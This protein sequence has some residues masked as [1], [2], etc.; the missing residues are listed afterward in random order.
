MLPAW[1]RDCCPTSL[2]LPPFAQ[3]QDQDVSKGFCKVKKT[4]PAGP[5]PTA[6][7]WWLTA[8]RWGPS[9]IG[10][11]PT[12][13][14]W[15]PTAVGWSQLPS[16]GGQ[17][18]S[19]GANCHQLLA[20]CRRLEPTA[21]GCWPTAICW[22]P[23]AI[24]WW[25]TAIGWRPTQSGSLGD[26]FGLGVVV[27]GQPQLVFPLPWSTTHA[28]CIP[29]LSHPE[30]S[31]GL[32]FRPPKRSAPS[33]THTRA[34]ARTHTRA[35]L[36]IVGTSGPAGPVNALSL[37]LS[38]PPVRCPLFPPR[39]L[40]PEPFPVP[41]LGPPPTL[42]PLAGPRPQELRSK[43]SVAQVQTKA[44]EDTHG[45]RQ[46]LEQRAEVCVCGWVCVLGVL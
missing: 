4:V 18:P 41:H 27:K 45:V 19:V 15:W 3:D 37:L 34:R 32:G 5:W 17:L 36:C 13:I 10:C 8:I 12:A 11:W 30:Q 33:T 6:I 44:Q 23:T 42:F 29:L 39:S 9:P 21:I 22:W 16:V 26:S 35:H 2:C 31:P 20:N 14:D 46:L 38:S 7:G 40:E 1:Y 43:D 25:P 28:V 24:R